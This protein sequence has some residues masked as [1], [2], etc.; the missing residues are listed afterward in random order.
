MNLI[1][2][3]YILN[4][5]KKNDKSCI[6][7]KLIV[8]N[9]KYKQSDYRDEKKILIIFEYEMK[10]KFAVSKKFNKIFIIFII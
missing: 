2:H 7:L 5:K 1:N 4:V 9:I 6:I 3:F 10:N 8:I